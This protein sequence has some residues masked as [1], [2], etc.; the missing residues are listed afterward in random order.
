[1]SKLRTPKEKRY[2]ELA[3]A[4]DGGP[5]K[6]FKFLWN[7]V[8]E[9]DKL[10]DETP[11]GQVEKRAKEV[12]AILE[13][14]K[15]NPPKDGKTPSTA[16]LLALIKPLIPLPRAG[17][18]GKTPTEDE[19]L[20]LI[21]SVMPD[22][23]DAI[24][25]PR[26]ERGPQGKTGKTG[27]MPE[28]EWNGTLIRF[29]K[30]NGEW[31]EFKNL[32]G[33]GGGG[34]MEYGG[35]NDAPKLLV[36]ADGKTHQGIGEIVVGENLTTTR[37]V[38]GVRIDA[39]GADI[40]FQATAPADPADGDLWADTSEEKGYIHAELNVLHQTQHVQYI[41]GVTDSEIYRFSLP[42]GQLLILTGIEVAKRG[43]GAEDADFTI[44][45][46]D[47][48]NTTQLA[49]C[50]LN[51]VKTLAVTTD[52]NIVYSIRVTNGVGSDI[53]ACY[54]IKGYYGYES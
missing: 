52:A 42:S 23:P 35:F 24:P 41:N 4:A 51:E 45:I 19:L 3:D 27:P 20:D 31:G 18:D 14:L 8:E 2:Q 11:Q 12:D 46:Y 7:L 34:G 25:G 16:E 5:L 49:T 10:L 33:P 28:H 9:I 1:M 17:Q 21:E 44:E 22:M 40:A 26:G 37:T 36:K 30:P 48:T 29:K 13:K 6:M 32:Q 43:G 50:N 47:V 38:N 15:A 53:D 54:T 39:E